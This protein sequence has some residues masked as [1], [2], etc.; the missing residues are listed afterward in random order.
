MKIRYK[1]IITF[2]IIG[3]IYA[4]MLNLGLLE[5]DDDT[6]DEIRD[7]ISELATSDYEFISIRDNGAEYHIILNLLNQPRSSS[8]AKG[9]K[10]ALCIQINTILGNADI[11]RDIQIK[12]IYTLF[13]GQTVS[14]GTLY[15]YNASEESVFIKD[16]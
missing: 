7:Q 15:Y 13:G 5:D 6:P 16:G 10:F 12:S 2:I 3:T 11:K 4:I 14:Y 8:E 9:W 1:F